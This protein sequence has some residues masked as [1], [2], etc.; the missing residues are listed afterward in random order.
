MLHTLTA[1]YPCPKSIEKQAM[2]PIQWTAFNLTVP[3]VPQGRQ[4]AK[5]NL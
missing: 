4:L 3:S 2:Q 1:V 5:Q